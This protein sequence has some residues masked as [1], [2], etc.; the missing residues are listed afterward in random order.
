[1]IPI[2]RLLRSLGVGVVTAVVVGIAL[3]V[4]DLYLTGHGWQSIRDPWISWTAAGVHLSVADVIWLSA[5][6]V[7]AV[8]AYRRG[9][10]R[11]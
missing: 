11:A 4:V 7:A 3:A 2:E 10:R 1:M 6:G 5:V 8:V 9:S